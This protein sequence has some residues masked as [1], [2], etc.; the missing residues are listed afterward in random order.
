MRLVTIASGGLIGGIIGYFLG[1]VIACDWLIP[2]S[3]LCGI[4]GVFITGPLGLIGGAIAGWL[5]SRPKTS[6]HH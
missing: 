5:F 3:N 1:V 6:S 2:N 4:F